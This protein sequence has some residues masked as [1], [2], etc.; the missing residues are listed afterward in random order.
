MVIIERSDGAM[1]LARRSYRNSGGV[2][3]G[4]P[5]RGETPADA[6]VREV[7][8]E[9]GIDIEVVG[10]PAVV[11]DAEAQR[12]DVIFKGRPTATGAEQVPV[13]SSPEIVEVAWFPPDHLPDLQFETSGALMAL[14][15]RAGVADGRRPV[16]IEEIGSA[17][18]GERGC[19]DV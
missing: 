6:A 16:P 15:R 14:A 18:G 9:V 11:V 1:L 5:K 19:R 4:L 2:P 10:D 12:V 17:S 7:R 8:E 13:P 3:G